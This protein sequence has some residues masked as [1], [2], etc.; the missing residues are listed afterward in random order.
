MLAFIEQ[1]DKILIFENTTQEIKINSMGFVY[2]GVPRQLVINIKKETG[3]ENFVET[4]TFK[5][6]TIIWAASIFKNAYTIEIN[7]AMSKQA[8]QRSDALSN[9]HFLTGNSKDVLKQLTTTLTD[10]TIFWL[11]GHYSGEGTGGEER[12]CP[13]M[14]ELDSIKVLQESFI[15]ID[16][17]RFFLGPPPSVHR[18]SDWPGID[19]IFAKLKTLFPN[20]YSTLIDDTIV[21][22]PSKFKYIL[23][24]DWQA[25]F[26]NR[27]SLNKPKTLFQKIFG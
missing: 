20:N 1:P 6:D 7:E 19:E 22:C 2:H 12:E 8:S 9:I 26:E 10:K 24:K 3:Y 15:L 14:E 23:D 4:G 27:Y 21:S 11:D 16:D 13:V 25:N 17:A 5:G 18:S